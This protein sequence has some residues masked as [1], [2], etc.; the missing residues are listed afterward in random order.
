LEKQIENI[1]KFGVPTIVAI[2]A[3]PTDTEAELKFVEDKCSEMGVNVV[4]SEVWA[5]GG[6]GGIDL[7]KKVVEIVEKG[8]SK[9]HTL[10][11]LELSAKEKIEKICKEIYGAAGVEF[12]TKALNDIAKFESDGIGNLPICMA[13]TQYSLSDNPKLLGRPR[14][15]TVTIREVKASAGAGFLVALTGDIMR[16]PGL[17]KVPAANKMDIL[18]SGEIIGLF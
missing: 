9:F 1:S 13:K 6:E 8:E 2:N 5:K 3:F 18:D 14:N 12:T 4:L 11:D 7:A 10:Y 17:P 15:F 16:M